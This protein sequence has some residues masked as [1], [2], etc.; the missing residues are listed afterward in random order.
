[1]KSTG[2]D[3]QKKSAANEIVVRCALKMVHTVGAR[4]ELH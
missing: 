3:I 2:Y 4:H 1:M